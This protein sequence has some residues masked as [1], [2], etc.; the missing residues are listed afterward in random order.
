[1]KTEVLK[2]Q[3]AAI[4]CGTIVSILSGA[5]HPAVAQTCTD[6]ASCRKCIQSINKNAAKVAKTQGREI[7]RC[8]KAAAKDA[9]SSAESCIDSDARGKVAAAVT[10]FTTKV[11]KDCSQAPAFGPDPSEAMMIAQ[12]MVDQPIA[13]LRSAF[14]D[15]LDATLVTTADDRAGAKCQQSLAKAVLKCHDTQLSVYHSCVKLGLNS[16]QITDES[17]L[18]ECLGHDPRGK[19][20]KICEN[21][22]ETT[23]N[24]ACASSDTDVLFEFEACQGSYLSQCAG[25]ATNCELCLGL[26]E[27]NGLSTD[28][29][30]KD[31]GLGN[32]SCIAPSACPD[33]CGCRVV[34]DSCEC[35]RVRKEIN[36]MTEEERSLYIATFITAYNHPDGQLKSYIDNHLSFFSRGLHNNG[37]FLPWHRGY[38]LQVE[39]RLQQ[40]DCRVTVPY[41]DWRLHPNILTASH[42]GN[43]ADQFSGDGD[44]STHCVTDGPFGENSDS[45]AV[46]APYLQTN[47]QCL[48][49]R[50]FDGQAAS[51]SDV[52]NLIAQYSTANQYNGFRNRL[53]HGPGLHDSV[54]CMVGGNMCS[55]RASNDPIFFSHHAN[56]DYIWWGWQAQSP[57]HLNAYSGNTDLNSLMPGSPYTPSQMLN[58]SSL[59]APGG[60][61][62]NPDCTVRVVYQRPVCSLEL[63]CP[64]DLTC[65]EDPDL[66]DA[67]VPDAACPTCTASCRATE[68]VQTACLVDG[69]CGVGQW[70]RPAESGTKVCVDFQQ[71][72]EACNCDKD[73]SCTATDSEALRCD[74]E[75]ECP[76]AS[77]SSE[78]PGICV[79]PTGANCDPGSYRAPGDRC[80]EIGSCRHDTDCDAAG[81]L[82]EGRLYPEFSYGSC[83][84]GNCE[85]VC[86]NPSRVDLAGV[87][88]GAC[89]TG[90][91]WGVIWGDCQ[92]ILG[93]AENLPVA[94][95]PTEQECTSALSEPGECPNCIDLSFDSDNVNTLVFESFF[96]PS[97][98]VEGRLFAGGN[99]DLNSYTVGF[100]LPQS[101]G[102]SDH[103]VVGGTLNFQVGQVY[104]GNI[105]YTGAASGHSPC[106]A[107]DDAS[108]CIL[109]DASQCPNCTVSHNP[110]RYDF[111]AARTHFETLST[112][113]GESPTNGTIDLIFGTLGFQG[114][115]PLLNHF[116]ASASQLAAAG[117]Y[118]FGFDLP[119]NAYAIITVPDSGEITFGPG[120]WELQTCNQFNSNCT[121]I[122]DLSGSDD[123]SRLLWNF[124][125]ATQLSLSGAFFGSILAPKADIITSNG[126]IWGQTISKSWNGL[127]QQNLG[128]F[129]FGGHVCGETVD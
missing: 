55:A 5:T 56:L 36:S 17:T 6:S 61:S 24:K 38:I 125:N 81:N 27:I 4:L 91:G 128:P 33:Q 37:A 119:T 87:D 89:G 14:G 45:A 116:V 28:C 92:P 49:R 43:A 11:A 85:S 58:L 70:C 40:E 124:P 114:T 1:M 96:A 13:L 7:L 75:L 101:N 54:H 8:M 121:V 83:V 15:S 41:W 78:H 48:E 18:A 127:M 26:A 46:F 117:T 72:G 42:W 10:K 63:A 9:S 109:F 126:V 3:V 95:F 60:S 73:I 88:L 113:I 20:E 98:D 47:G 65:A 99:V 123:G 93:C 97:G 102:T 16:G 104:G 51:T 112:E 66:P 94:L 31:D 80:L 59:P 77:G 69:E 106:Q 115:D 44:P 82:F 25:E 108:S 62:T 105:V 120:S 52:Q 110:L 122:R 64:G 86:G 2:L 129:A 71:T 68:V 103:L 90:L 53:E 34:G 76:G 19:I 30:L 111:T 118:G 100:G 32:G 50:L 74:N 107:G 22:L 57:A 29:D 21:K 79:T 67:C 39:N 35:L 84:F 12:Q 23:I